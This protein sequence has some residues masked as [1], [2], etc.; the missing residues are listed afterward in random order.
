MGQFMG[1]HIAQYKPDI[2]KYIPVAW[3]SH[4]FSAHEKSMSQP[5][6]ELFAIVYALTQESLLLGFSKVIVHTDCR[7]L[8]YL[9]RFSRICSKLMRWQLILSSYDLEV[10]FEPSDT[11]GIKIADMLSRRPDH[12]RITNRKPKQDEIDQLPNIDYKD[13]P[14]MTYY[15]IK[16]DIEK[17][18]KEVPP[19]SPEVIKFFSEKWIHPMVKPEHLACNQDIV[20]KIATSENPLEDY[21]ATY[22]HPYVYTP[23]HLAFKNDISPSGRLINLVLEE[24]PGMSLQML[25]HH[26]LSD[27]Y[28]GPKMKQIIDT[29]QALP[30]Y[31]LKNGILLKINKDPITQIA[32]QICVPRS[33]ALQLIGKFHYSVFGSHADLKK[34]MNNLKKRFFIKQLKSECQQVIKTCQICTLNKSHNVVKQPFGTK[35]AVT[36]PRQLFALDICTVDS[37]AKDVDPQLPTSFFIITDCWSLYT[38]CVP[39]NADATAQEI[40]EKFTMHIIQPFGIPRLGITTDGGSNFSCQLTNTF[41]AVLG[42]QQ[43]RISPYNA[44]A[45]PAERVNRAILSGL[46]YASQQYSLEPETFKNLVNYIVLS[47]NTSVLSQINFS[48]YQL[49]L[50][51][52]YEPAALTSFVTIHEAEKDYS[53]FIEGL[54]KTQH[55]VENLVNKKYQELRDVRYKHKEEKSKR[56]IYAPGMQVMVKIQPDQTKRAH[57]LR[58]RYKGPYK[59]IKE[60]QNNV[61]IIPWMENRAVK[62][63]DKYKNEARHVPKFE[64]YLISKDRLKPCN[65]LTFYYDDALARR[66]YQ[67][68][69]DSIRDV[70]PIKEVQRHNT[71]GQF[72]YQQPLKKPFLFPAEIGIKPNKIATKTSDIKSNN[73]YKHLND[74]AITTISSSSDDNDDNDETRIPRHRAMLN[75]INHIGPNVLEDIVQGNHQFG[76][77]QQPDEHIDQQERLDEEPMNIGHRD[78][79]INDDNIINIR[80]VIGN[81]SNIREQPMLQPRIQGTGN[82]PNTKSVSQLGARAKIVPT[83]IQHPQT[84]KPSTSRPTNQQKT[85]RMIRPTSKERWVARPT[86]KE[87][88][89]IPVTGI[90]EAGGKQTINLS[91]ISTTKSNDNKSHD[92][93]PQSVGYHTRSKAEKNQLQNANQQKEKSITDKLDSRSRKGNTQ[94]RRTNSNDSVENSDMPLS[95]RLALKGKPGSASNS[96]IELEDS[97]DSVER[98]FLQHQSL[99]QEIEEVSEALGNNFRNIE[100]QLNELEKD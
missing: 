77:N 72:N 61:E 90:Q 4:K 65:N 7:S 47:W 82:R 29:N 87:R 91:Q 99:D 62:F 98:Q 23:E 75:P 11:I 35:I 44:R 17:H 21:K 79:V 57:K 37:K 9:F 64:K 100:Q 56:S 52:P 39:I 92:T 94:V 54:I 32:Y 71:P 12:K 88:W 15:E 31:A 34:L 97:F 67:E 36:G 55:M 5:E 14:I 43:F 26:Q 85:P 93:S 59:I 83:R 53:Q 10:Y 96:E 28:F 13:K 58:P 3:G 49:F 86:S 68:F 25:K 40:L 69:W 38:I 19:I 6:A 73:Q 51:T 76:N 60:Y 1:Y 27:P 45:N 95:I 20:K 16:A 2:K 46:R 22:N 30:D 84:N 66:F 24:A 48:P 74:D 42:L 81:S 33:L 80:G 8:T 50:S 70:Q 89:V 18:L 63:V 41:S 78:R